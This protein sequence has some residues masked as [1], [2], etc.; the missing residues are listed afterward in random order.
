[1]TE[2]LATEITLGGF[3]DF[4]TAT[5]SGRIAAVQNVI[6]NE[7]GSYE[8]GR[9]FYRQIRLAI[10]EGIANA[11]DVRRVQRAAAECSPRRRTHYEALEAGWTRWRRG[12]NLAVF[13]LPQHWQAEGL[14]VRVSPQF[15]WKQRT[16]TTLIWPYFKEA[17]LSRDAVQAAVRIMEQMFPSSHGRPAVLDIRRGRIYYA[18]KRRRNFDAWLSG[19]AAAF[20]SMLSSI[21]NVA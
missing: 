15:T 17:E 11:D 7:F 8:P 5:A 18:Q 3:V 4:A 12:K 19:E 10:A 16:D 2:P 9:D 20:L 6:D 13:S 14:D 1:M 21:R